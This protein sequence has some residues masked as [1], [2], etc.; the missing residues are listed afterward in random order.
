M[1]FYSFTDPQRDGRLSY[2]GKEAKDL[3]IDGERVKSVARE[4][5]PHSFV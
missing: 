1:D 5:I 3:R 2:P 4:L